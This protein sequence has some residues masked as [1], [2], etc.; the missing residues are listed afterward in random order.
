[1]SETIDEGVRTLLLERI[2]AFEHL[3]LLRRMH[4]K[5]EQRWTPQDVAEQL[6][7]S[8][9]LAEAALEH[10]VRHQLIAAATVEGEEGT[11]IT[12]FTYRPQDPALAATVDRLTLAYDDSVLE[13]MKLMSAN[14]IERARNKALRFFS[15]AF[16]LGKKKKDG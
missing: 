12:A 2:E 10:L 6:R 11:M 8:Q 5:P 13:I 1:M 15:D 7:I 4:R 9:T 16:I 3:E 14:A